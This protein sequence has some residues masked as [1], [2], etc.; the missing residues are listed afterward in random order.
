MV[1][2]GMGE[3]RHTCRVLVGTAVGKRPLWKCRFRLQGNIQLGLKINRMEG[4]RL[5]SS[6]A[7]QEKV[8]GSCEDGYSFPTLTLP[9]QVLVKTVTPSLLLPFQIKFLWR[10]LLLPY[11]YPSKASSCEDGY[12]FP[13]L[14]LP[15]QVLRRVWSNGSSCNFQDLFVS[16]TSSSISLRLLLPRL[17]FTYI[18]PSI[19]PSKPCFKM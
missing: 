18:L 19:L 14:T 1:G 3:K 8:A 13:T 4:F 9:K 10:R 16:L 6:G 12:S 7:G 15:N 17:S 2:V 11:S 5:D